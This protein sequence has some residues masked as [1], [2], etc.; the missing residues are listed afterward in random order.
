MSLTLLAT[1]LNG[2]GPLDLHSAHTFE[3]MNNYPFR[4]RFRSGVST[5]TASARPPIAAGIAAPPKSSESCQI[6]TFPGVAPVRSIQDEKAKPGA[7]ISQGGICCLTCS[8]SAAL[9]DLQHIAGIT[10]E[11]AATVSDW[12]EKCL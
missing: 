12:R 5:L 7:N 4:V 2:C 11:C 10:S 9:D 3:P 6:Q 1:L 8:R